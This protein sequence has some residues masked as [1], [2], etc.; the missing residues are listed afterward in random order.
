MLYAD[1]LLIMPDF[2]QLTNFLIYFQWEFGERLQNKNRL[3]PGGK[4]ESECEGKAY[5]CRIKKKISFLVSTEGM[6]YALSLIHI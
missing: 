6:I 5:V 3:S 2:S 4:R 1:F